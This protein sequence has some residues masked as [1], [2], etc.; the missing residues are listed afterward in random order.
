M[1]KS[2]RGSRE[3]ITFAQELSDSWTWRYRDIS[4]Q[5]D[6]ESTSC[7]REELSWG[8]RKGGLVERGLRLCLAESEGDE[9]KVHS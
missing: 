8:Q 6:F 1:D 3:T 4:R 2:D 5:G 7:L 9:E